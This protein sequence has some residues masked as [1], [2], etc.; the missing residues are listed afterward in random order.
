[1]FLVC[2]LLEKWRFSYV[3]LTLLRNE[4]NLND[5]CFW[6]NCFLLNTFHDINWARCSNEKRNLNK[7]D[8]AS[9]NSLSEHEKIR[10]AI[11]NKI[12]C[13]SLLSCHS[14][15]SL[16]FFLFLCPFKLEPCFS[17]QTFW[18]LFSC[19]L[20]FELSK[21]HVSNLLLQFERAHFRSRKTKKE[22]WLFFFIQASF[23]SFSKFSYFLS[24]FV[25]LCWTLT[26]YL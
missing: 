4:K 23:L 5:R 15:N 25:T 1:M 22:L 7:F 24:T 14:W 13:F 17:W 26:S 6:I 2:L 9:Q 10:R 12:Y 21:G 3:M 11:Q 19:F 18:S 16:K 20:H 8:S